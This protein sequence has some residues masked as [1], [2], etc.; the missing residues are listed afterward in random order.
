MFL[1]S[2]IYQS[3]IIQDIIPKWR[4]LGVRLKLSYGELNTIDQNADNKA[5]ETSA[6]KML[7]EWRGQKRDAA[8][9][10]KLITAL[11]ACKENRYAAKLQKGITINQCG[12]LAWIYIFH[13]TTL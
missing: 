4:Q 3:G 5:N 13:H 11:K 8:T 2:E 1:V 12:W 7:E 10:D 6:L 9:S